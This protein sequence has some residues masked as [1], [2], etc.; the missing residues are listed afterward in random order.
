MP[1][2]EN[3][4]F[5]GE[6]NMKLRIVRVVP[7][8]LGVGL[9]ILAV[10]QTGSG[11]IPVGTHRYILQVPPGLPPPPLPAGN[12]LTQEGVALGQRLFHEVR[13]SGN[14]TQS[15]SSCHRGDV[16]LSDA[17]NALSTGI[18]GLRGTRNAP[19][20]FN[21]A[22]Q[23]TYFWDGRAPSLR[24]QAL[25]PI[26]N[27]V[28]MHQSL[29]SAVG[30]LSADPS[31]VAQF[32]KAFGTPGV[33][34]QRIGLSLEQF[35]LTVFAGDSKF[36]RAQRGQATLTP[37]EQRGFQVFRTPFNPKL[38][39]FGGDCARC[40]GGPLFS[41]F[42]FK[43]NGLDSVPT[44]FGRML[45]TGLVIDKAKFKT[46]SL[47]NVAVSGPYMHDGRYATLE[48]VAAH[49]SDDIA[50]SA[51]VDPKLARENGGVHLSQADQAAL[52]AFMKTLTDSRFVGANPAP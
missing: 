2:R 32:A 44:D 31:Y 5:G 26:Q 10:A 20:L 50:P 39:Q 49:Y 33:N 12:P 27:P 11:P 23:R 15:C 36:D 21:L 30:K 40:H 38:G 29:A 1:G 4:V 48:E 46:P 51:T 34:A 14:N 47:R 41:D 37:Q 8:L 13:L 22:Y 25:A 35:M 3:P 24:V 16:A 28:E 7:S 9:I 52:V 43:N 19:S 17:P 6:L 42:Q 18:D 45:V